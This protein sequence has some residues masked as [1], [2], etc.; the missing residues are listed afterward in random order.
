[1]MFRLDRDGVDFDRVIYLVSSLERLTDLGCTW[2][3]SDR[4]AA[5]NLAT[6]VEATGDLEG[7]IDWPLMIQRY[8]GYTA[9]DPDRPDRRS[10]ECLVHQPSAMAGVR[11]HRDQERCDPG[12]SPGVA[13]FRWPYCPG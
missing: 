13:E 6:Y 7:H 10:A 12:G 3:A 11:E 4:N 5:Q 2:I 8:W 9:D 1:M